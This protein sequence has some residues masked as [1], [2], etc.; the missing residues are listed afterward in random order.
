MDGGAWWATV[1]GVA[2]LDTTGQLSLT[3]PL[4]DDVSLDQLS[5]QAG[6]RLSSRETEPTETISLL[7]PPRQ[8][9]FLLSCLVL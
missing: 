7:T 6:S 9:H 4:P 3:P 1:H 8:T 2:E 5:P